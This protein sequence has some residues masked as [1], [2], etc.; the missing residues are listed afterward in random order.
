MDIERLMTTII[1]CAVTVKRTLG[2][3]FLENV[4]KNALFVEFKELG[5]ECSLEEPLTV[6]YKGRPVGQYRADII[7]E[8]SIIIELKV[9]ESIA[10]EHEY[11][12]VNYL[13]ATGINH[14][15]IINFGET[16]MKFKR[17]FRNPQ[18]NNLCHF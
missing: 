8:K 17:K 7:V 15:L 13:R 4:Y 18:K 9:C 1:G 2:E 6:I 11:Q 5:I 10:K 12:L 3:G 14:G 16:P